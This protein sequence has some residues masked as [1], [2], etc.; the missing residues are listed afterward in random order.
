MNEVEPTLLLGVQSEENNKQYCMQN[1]R[2]EM[3]EEMI[4]LIEMK[5]V[6][7]KR[8]VLGESVKWVV[9]E[10]NLRYKLH[11]YTS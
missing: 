8:G 6:Q 9:S 3:K 11:H 4:V 7:N 10:H 2:D 1:R 5:V